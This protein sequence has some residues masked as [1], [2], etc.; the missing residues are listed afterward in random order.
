ME[1]AKKILLVDLDDIRRKSRIRILTHAGYDVEIRADHIEAE[2]IDHE[3][4]F[5]LV[6]VALHQD[7]IE[8][9]ENRDHL[10]WVKPRLPVLPL[11]DVSAFVPPGNLS[12]LIETGS[13]DNLMRKIAA[14][15]ASS[16]YI[17]DLSLPGE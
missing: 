10:C 7:A 14:M 8:A 12:S 4:A 13:P 5:D 6:I 3:S 9:A 17:R 11:A 1:S 2:R 15:L 16:T